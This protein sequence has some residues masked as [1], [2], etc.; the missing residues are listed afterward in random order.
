MD[1]ELLTNEE[2]RVDFDLS[3]DNNYLLIITTDTTEVEN[4][5]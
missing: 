3:V 1:M 2:L 5:G 4:F